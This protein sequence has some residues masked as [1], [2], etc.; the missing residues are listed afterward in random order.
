MAK[1][2]EA[3]WKKWLKKAMKSPRKPK[4]VKAHKSV[5][6]YCVACGVKH[7]KG[8]HRFHGKGSFKRTH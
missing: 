8:S 1:M 4:V 6:S 5:R 7:S 3:Q 2:T